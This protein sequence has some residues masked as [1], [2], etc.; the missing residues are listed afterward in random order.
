MK[1]GSTVAITAIVV[2]TLGLA[3]QAS[4]QPLKPFGHS[5]VA[6]NGVRFCPTTSRPNRVPTFDGVPLDAD[7]TLPQTG[8]GPFPTI[9]MLHGWGGSKTNFESSSPSDGYS[10]VY[11]AHLGYAVLN[12][13]ARGFGDS[14]GGASPPDHSGACGKGYIHLAD[15]RFE[16]R[17]TQYLLGKLADEGITKPQA[18]GVTGV[19]Y[20]GG[21]SMELAF[22]RDQIRLPNGQLA[23]WHSP[24]GKH[25]SIAGAYPRWP[26]SD[27]VDALIPNGRF[28]DTQV[29]PFQQSLN[30][31]GVPIK[32]YI[33][34]L[35][36]LGSATGYYC[37]TA[38]ASTPCTDRDAN[39]P[40][41][42][43]EV[44]AG[45]PLSA[46]GLSAIQGI[47]DHSSPYRLAFLPGA[48]RPA[49][50]LIQNGWTDDLF[51]P[52][53]ALRPYNF[54]RSHYP[55]FPVS[56]QFG[57]LGHSRGTNKAATDAYFFDQARG[58]FRAHLKNLSGA[59]AA[60]S[61]T[62][63]TQ[64]CPASTPDGGPFKAQS[65]SAIHNPGVTFGAASSKTFNS[66][67]GNQNVA[68]QFD[69]IAGTSDA[70]KTVNTTNE[71]NTA[72]Y[73][74]LFSNNGGFT[75]LGLPTVR[76]DVQTTGQFG[77]ITARLWDL[78]PN[79]Q[80]RLISRG[81]YSLRN[82]QAGH[83][84]FQLHGNGYHFAKGDI[85]ELQLLG[86]DAPYYQPSNGAFSVDVS[87]LTVSLP[88]LK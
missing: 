30:P 49:P 5:C 76:A 67:G 42:F 36:A 57:D 34:G 16:V 63:F 20:G 84:V 83:I 69:P 62:A 54:L 47:Y 66:A 75:M 55:G 33:G 87:N 6:Q 3:A 61:V 29:A 79:G 21:Q 13:T 24:D 32:S 50:L 4:A 12:Y 43:A 80:Q 40:M 17:D 52:E 35:Y 27:L 38:P 28:L 26:W 15:S 46:D 82:N 68:A 51:P 77:E 23:P 18:I 56:L 53:H 10:N 78:L 85:A 9:V 44:Q 22:L 1:G 14:C 37:G 65:W 70:C 86:R 19:S 88:E 71:P 48:S 25:M 2:A 7:V 60:G 45:Q 59:P 31:I 74:H 8:A 39:L 73:K 72:T 58:F 11:F 64:T 81:V 41:D